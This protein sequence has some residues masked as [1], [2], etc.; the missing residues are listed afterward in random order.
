MNKA[1]QTARPRF[2]L[3]IGFVLAAMFVLVLLYV[4]FGQRLGFDRADWPSEFRSNGERIYFTATSASGRPIVADGQ[5]MHMAMMGGSCA[6]CHEADRSGGRLRPRFWVVA[7]AL[8]ADALFDGHGEGEA[9]DG[10][11]DHDSYTDETLRRAI[12]QG[13]DP[14][15][16]PLDP[17]MPRWSMAPED[18]DDLIAYLKSP[19]GHDH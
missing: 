8:T 15:G 18:L 11:G 6:A 1:Q 17:E 2:A 9:D 10:H 19:A 13:T 4:L 16:G 3:T 12:T 5:G 14:S 7:P